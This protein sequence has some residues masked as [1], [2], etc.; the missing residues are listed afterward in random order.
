LKKGK[1]I[2]GISL[3]IVVAML[4]AVPGDSAYAGTSLSAIRSESID[5]K[6][7][8]ISE[9]EQAKKN[10][11]NSISDAKKIK[12]EL[13]SLKTSVS[14][15]ITKLDGEIMDIEAKIEELNGQIEKKE[16]EIVV[17]TDELN[18]AIAVENAQYEAMKKRIKFMYEQGD[19]FYLEII[20][21]ATSF[22]DFLAKADYVEALS[23][24]SQQK[25]DEYK[26]IR[27]YTDLCKQLLESEKA[28]LD[29]TKA[30]REQEEATL[31][32]LYA[33]K[34]I[35][36]AN[37]T[38]QIKVKENQIIEYQEDLEEQTAA[39]AALEAA[40]LA[41]QKAIAAANGIAL[42]YDGGKFTW[43]CPS[44][45]AITDEFGYRTDPINGRTSYHSGLDMGAPGGSPI[46]AAYDGV[47]VAAAYDSSM[48][49]YVMINHGGGLYTVYMHS[50]KLLCKKD[51]IVT[52]GEKI[53]LVG[54]TGRSTGN[55][56]HFSVRYNGSYV[57]PNP[58]LGRSK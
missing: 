10:I 54:T 36:L 55:H 12:A 22:G 56:L 57:D 35:E 6:K 50:S 34:E 5:A 3:A 26:Q 17:I 47:V 44:Y 29:E 25:L 41:E 39:I 7:Q 51:D 31:K 53:A 24:Y 14:A 40:V 16:A 28:T 1:F 19:T 27:E 38:S 4:L 13:E 2:T 46:L 18:E 37:Y 33:E 20:V 42:V 52:R 49:N 58:Y 32:E 43:P 15:Y 9:S 45:V 23:S 21:N 30:A 11:Q 8:Q 48:G